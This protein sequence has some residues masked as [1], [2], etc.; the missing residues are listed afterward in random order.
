ML[1]PSRNSF[2]CH[3]EVLYLQPKIPPKR[4]DMF[5]PLTGGCSEGLARCVLIFLENTLM[6]CKTFHIHV[7]IN[8]RV[9]ILA[10]RVL[11][12]SCASYLLSASCVRVMEPGTTPRPSST[13]HRTAPAGRVFGVGP[14][15]GCVDHF[16]QLKPSTR[17][18]ETRKKNYRALG[19][20]EGRQAGGRGAA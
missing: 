13:L 3:E 8:T 5:S 11:S 7:H 20:E 4:F 19:D 1:F 15:P 16:G 9:E 10:F 6:R 2:K 17:L 14:Y 18:S 12:F